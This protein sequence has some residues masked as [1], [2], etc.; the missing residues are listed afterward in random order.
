MRRSFTQAPRTDTRRSISTRQV[1][2]YEEKKPSSLFDIFKRHT[3]DTANGEMETT[4]LQ[5]LIVRDLR[6]HQSSDSLNIRHQCAKPFHH[7]YSEDWFHVLLR[8]RT[9][10]SLFM[11]VTIWT[12]FLLF[13]AGVYMVVDM[14][15][16]EIDCGL[17]HVPNTIHFGAAFAFS[18]ETT[19]T[20]GYGIPNGG[21]AF[22]E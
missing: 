7:W 3:D 2:L 14:E 4:P 19:T 5:R 13:F 22:F 15:N 21:N 1:K 20:V 8:L 18:L 11:F 6:Y 16:P 12:A 9:S 17:G 10:V